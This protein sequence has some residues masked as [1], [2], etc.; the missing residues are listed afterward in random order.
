M[1]EAQST[2]AAKLSN[3]MLALLGRYKAALKAD[4]DAAGAILT[5]LNTAIDTA[6]AHC[7]L[8][9]YKPAIH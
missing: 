4:S 5:R 3:K 2:T 7:D 8:I 9:E 1:T 6:N